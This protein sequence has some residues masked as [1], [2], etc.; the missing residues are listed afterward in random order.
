MTSLG[1]ITGI[2]SILSEYFSISG[3]KVLDQIQY[4]TTSF[5]NTGQHLDEVITS[6]LCEVPLTAYIEGRI[7]SIT[8][9]HPNY[10]SFSKIYNTLGLASSMSVVETQIVA[11]R[12]VRLTVR[13]DLQGTHKVGYVAK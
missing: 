4:A 1:H 3:L 8:P 11:R 10:C 13:M 9:S 5:Y 12:M 2:V 7:P 6:E